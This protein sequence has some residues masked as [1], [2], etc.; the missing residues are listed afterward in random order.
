MDKPQR[1]RITAII[2]NR[3][4]HY[5]DSVASADYYS[6]F[7]QK[8]T[9]LT[10]KTRSLT[11]K[12]YGSENSI[13][14]ASRL[15]RLIA[16]FIE[17]MR[18]K[19]APVFDFLEYKAVL[20]EY[21]INYLEA[22]RK[23]NYDGGCA[24]YGETLFVLY[25]DLFITATINEIDRELQ[26]NPPFLINPKTSAVLEIDVF[27]E[28]FKLGFEFQGEHHYTDLKTQEKD[29][30]KINECRN[31]EIVLIPVNISQ[32]NGKII[33]A[34]VINSIKVFLGIHDLF[35]L[36]RDTFKPPTTIKSKQLLNFCKITE[37]LY[38]S[39]AIFDTSTA[40]LDGEAAKYISN[41]QFR[42]PISS[43]IPA[44]RQTPATGDFD[45]VTLYRGLK[46][47]AVFRKVFRKST[48]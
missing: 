43:N 31:K 29:L 24:S 11:R 3:N 21:L 46:R 48:K 33:Q 22:K 19:K 16:G 1:N 5:L 38:T 4:Q 13:A 10:R 34:L 44:P 7:Q 8:F 37:R 25:L 36:K 41:V 28:N 14:E 23:S 30:F 15:G 2:K 17:D 20:N 32:L 39:T 42:S 47:I 27:F 6:K 26:A 40:W 35:T 45:I 9:N 18:Q 12:E